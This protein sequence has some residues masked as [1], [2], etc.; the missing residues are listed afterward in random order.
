MKNNDDTKILKSC[1]S[2]F[3][4]GEFEASTILLGKSEDKYGLVSYF[5][6]V[7]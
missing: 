4:R 1:M 2:N 6:L 7:L 5:G 3:S